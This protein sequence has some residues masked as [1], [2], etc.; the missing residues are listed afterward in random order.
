MTVPS[1][2]RPADRE[3]IRKAR[4]A[5]EAL[6]RSA[7]PALHNDIPSGTP[8]GLSTAIDERL[9]HPPRTP[10]ILAAASATPLRDPPQPAT[11]VTRQRHASHDD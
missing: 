9:S 6:F 4:E 1:D 11:P 7:Q 3:Q 10:R 5:A 2:S 8:N